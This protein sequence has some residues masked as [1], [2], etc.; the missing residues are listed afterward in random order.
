MTWKRNF[1]SCGSQ[2]AGIFL[3]HLPIQ[4]LGLSLAFHKIEL[5]LNRLNC[6]ERVDS[7]AKPVNPDAL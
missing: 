7:I 5:E 2:T 1:Y 4:H 6:F 3:T